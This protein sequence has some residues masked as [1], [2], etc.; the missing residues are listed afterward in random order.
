[1]AKKAAAPRE[2]KKP[3]LKSQSFTV[4]LMKDDIKDFAKALKDDDTQIEQVAVKIN[5]EAC[6]LA[7]KQYNPHSPDW[8]KFLRSV[9]GTAL[10]KLINAGSAA[11]LLLNASKRLFAVMFGN[12]R[13]LLKADSYEENFGLKVVLNSVNPEKVRSVDVRSLD[14]VPV[15]VRSQ[16][17]VATEVAGFGLNVEQDLLYAATG[18]P[19]DSTLGK[20]ITGKDSLKLSLPVNLDG[21]RGLL[22]KLLLQF[23]DDAYKKVFPW[24]DHLQEVRDATIISKLDEALLTQIG[25]EDFDRTWLSVPDILD[26]VDIDGFRYQRPK[27]GE[28]HADIAWE[29]YLEFLKTTDDDILLATLKKHTVYAISQSTGQVKEQW[30]V[31]KCV[32]GEIEFGDH[33]Y[34]LTG[35]KWFRIDVDYLEEIDAALEQIPT[36]TI[37]LP[38]YAEKNEAEYNNK[39]QQTDKNYFALMDKKNISY[40]GGSSKI[41]FCDLYTKDRK[42]IHVKRYGGSSVLS[43]LFSQGLVSARLTMIDPKFREKVNAELPPSH[44]LP[45]DANPI[46]A[47]KYEVI[48]AIASNGKDD[49]LALPLFSKINLRSAYTQLVQMKFKVSTTVIKV[50]A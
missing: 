11:V 18:E 35:G 34:A 22:E 38:D 17:S 19:L 14:A 44:K 6:L 32:Y 42:L 7:F 15:N 46:D 12:G 33:T 39:V 25:G 40:G 50:V 37:V 13:H 23:N 36:A 8:V 5:G 24:I 21:L 4:F 49:T 47:S 2:P 26:W 31:Y 27:Q 10:D 43:H 1:M 16:A 48:Y 30:P 20:T 28:P 45:K 41:E 9:A 29:S 3:K